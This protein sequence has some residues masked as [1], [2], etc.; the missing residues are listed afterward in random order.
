[1]ANAQK[2]VT[3]ACKLP[4]G[5]MLQLYKM[6]D[7]VEPVSGGGYRQIKVAQKVGEPIKINGNS[8]KQNA[9]PSC[10]IRDSFAFTENVPKDH[11]DAWLEQNQSLDFVKNGLIFAHETT[12]S[13]VDQAKDHKAIR[14][15]FERLN[16]DAKPAGIIRA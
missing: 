12:N 11:W 9:L 6:I 14:S 10:I 1:M 15:G 13:V 4:H 16:P 5:I 8:H 3:V 2:T 7:G